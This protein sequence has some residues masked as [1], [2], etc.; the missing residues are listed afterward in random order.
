MKLVFNVNSIF[1]YL[2]KN[3]KENATEPNIIKGLEQIVGSLGEIRDNNLRK[4]LKK[5]IEFFYPDVHAH[6]LLQF[7]F[8][9]KTYYYSHLIWGEDFYI[10]ESF[11]DCIS[12]SDPTF[13]ITN[14]STGRLFLENPR[15]IAEYS[16]DV[17][18]YVEAKENSNTIPQTVETKLQLFGIYDP[19][20]ERKSVEGNLDN[21]GSDP[22]SKVSSAIFGKATSETD[23]LPKEPTIVFYW[24]K[25]Q[26]KKLLTYQFTSKN[27]E[28]FGQAN[29]LGN[30]I[31][32]FS[33]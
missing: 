13:L 23:L 18:V 9:N 29:I 27:L 14:S 17:Q 10:S 6:V 15:K 26:N 32:S 1:S 4:E 31:K 3:K 20:K 33:Q 11:V 5:Y 19:K 8:Q 2:G 22:L 12:I 30:I 21:S 16:Y 7:N 25:N 24:D 28:Y